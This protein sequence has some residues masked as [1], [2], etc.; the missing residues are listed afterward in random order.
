M[1]TKSWKL[2]G[3]NGHRQRI[4][5]EPSARYDWSDGDN[6]RIVEVINSDKTGTNDYSILRITRN[7]EAECERECNG[8]ISDGFFENVRI[9]SVEETVYD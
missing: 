7:T 9:G 2:N 1:F 3:C 8:Q 6:I 4:S 5:F